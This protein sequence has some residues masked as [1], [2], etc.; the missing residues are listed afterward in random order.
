MVCAGS[1]DRAT[2]G[3]PPELDLSRPYELDPQ[4]AL[5]HEPF[6]AL[7]YHYGNRRLNFLRSAELV[8]LVETL[9]QH[10]SASMA[11]EAA[12]IGP[13]RAGSFEEALRSLLSSEVIR[14][15]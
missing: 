1:T 6:G 9:G 5:R 8:R 7:A 13:E 15:R 14:A 4:V 2:S 12:E 3:S 11:M 10:P